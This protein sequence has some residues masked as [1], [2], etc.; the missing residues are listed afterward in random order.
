M[1]KNLKQQANN[2]EPVRK[3]MDQLDK[4]FEE[5]ASINSRLFRY[6][7]ENHGLQ[8]TETSLREK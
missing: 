1:S 3:P 7:E 6:M 8:D 4:V 5:L 2:E